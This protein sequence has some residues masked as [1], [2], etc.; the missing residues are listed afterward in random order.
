MPC[1][2]AGPIRSGRPAPRYWATNVVRYSPVPVQRAD[3]R[4][5]REEAGHRPR[6]RLRRV[7][8]QEQPVHE[9]LDRE[10]HVAE[11]ERVGDGEHLAAATG[12][13]PSPRD[14]RPHRHVRRPPG[15]G[16]S[17]AHALAS[18][19]VAPDPGP[20]P[21]PRLAR[22]RRAPGPDRAPR[23]QRL[24]P[25]DGTPSPGLGAGRGR[26]RGVPPRLLP[27]RQPRRRHREARPRPRPRGHGPVADAHPADRASRSGRARSAAPTRSATSTRSTPTTAPTTTC[28]HLVRRGPRARA[29]GHPRRRRQPHRLG[30]RDD[31]DARSST[32]ATPRGGCS[33]RTRTGRTWPSST[34]RTRSCART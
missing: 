34:T 28:K 3:D 30:Q 24:R 14:P 21:R 10:G 12:T 19:H 16:V 32:C 26:L 27:G 1:H 4:P 11:D 15:E 25:R 29:A 13:A 2:S 7:P 22:G 17:L 8:G 33:R 23:R 9:R 18:P 5:D 20:P 6:H 31:G